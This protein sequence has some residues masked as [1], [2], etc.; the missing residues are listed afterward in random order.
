MS[1]KTS[2]KKS[3]QKKAA[4]QKITV[5]QNE[6]DLKDMKLPAAVAKDPRKAS[7]FYFFFD[8][9]A[10][11]YGSYRGSAI[12][13]GFSEEYANNITHL[14]PKWLSDFIGAQDFVNLA[15]THLRE[16]LMLPNIVQ[17]MS[18]FG[19]IERTEIVKEEIGVYKSGPKKGQ[20]KFKNVKVK[21]PV[22][23]PNTSIIK[24]KNDAAKVVLPAHDEKYKPK[25]SAT[26]NIF[27]F[28]LKAIKNEYS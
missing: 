26:K 4:I 24:V 23:V 10:P 16:V 15:E 17:A 3:P 7:F 27:N 18:A 20:T 25:G 12:K 14:K 5:S 13:A 21:V 2:T 11:T 22:M 8:R 6:L 1:R 28:N 9:S 19:P